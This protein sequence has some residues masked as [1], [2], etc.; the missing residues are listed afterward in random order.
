MPSLVYTSVSTWLLLHMVGV[1]SKPF[2]FTCIFEHSSAVIVRIKYIHSFIYIV[3]L[4]ELH[5]LL[6]CPLVLPMSI[7]NFLSFS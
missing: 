1:T 4:P 6:E 5:A 3:V 7:S 2:M